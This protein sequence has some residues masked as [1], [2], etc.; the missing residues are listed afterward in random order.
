MNLGIGE[1]TFCLDIADAHFQTMYG[2]FLRAGWCHGNDAGGCIEMT[3]NLR[4]QDLLQGIGLHK[5]VY[6]S[7]HGG[8]E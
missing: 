2:R 5:A 3:A 1:I 8:G 7:C 4:C 6:G